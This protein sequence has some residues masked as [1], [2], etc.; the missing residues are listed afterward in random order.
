M[1]LFVRVETVVSVAQAEKR[2]KERACSRLLD[3]R[4]GLSRF[5]RSECFLLALEVEIRNSCL[6]RTEA[7][8]QV[9]AIP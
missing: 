5:G 8:A 7:Q 4:R 6:G 3:C 1:L 2:R 9:L